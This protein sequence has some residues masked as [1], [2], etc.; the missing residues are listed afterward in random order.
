MD[1]PSEAK[2]ERALNKAM[3]REAY[4]GDLLQSIE[5]GSIQ[6]EKIDANQ[7]PADLRNMSPT[8]RK[9]EIEKRLAQRR[10]LRA[11]IVTLSKQRAEFL[12]AERKKLGV[13]GDAFD[14]A[15]VTALKEQLKRK[16]IK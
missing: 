1:A 3:N 16:G 2:A 13:K 7:L 11:Q 15:V 6:V 14:T 12:A 8:Q 4:M 10:E 9:Q 5:N